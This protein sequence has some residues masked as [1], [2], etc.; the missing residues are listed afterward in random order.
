M[1]GTAASSLPGREEHRHRPYTSGYL[2]RTCGRCRDL[3]RRRKIN[4]WRYRLEFDVYACLLASL[5]DDGLGFLARRV[6][7]GLEY[8]PQLLAVLRADAVRAALPAGLVQPLVRLLDTEPPIRVLRNKA[9]R[10]VDEIS[11]RHSGAPVDMRLNSGPIDK[12]TQRMTDGG[13]AE[14]RMFRLRTR[15]LT[16]HLGP[17]IGVVDRDMLD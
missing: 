2:H 13:I 11:R 8:E 6:D 12:Q 7:R 14:Q 1:T 3:P 5:L 17:R 15:T 4:R 16:V 9:L 10:T